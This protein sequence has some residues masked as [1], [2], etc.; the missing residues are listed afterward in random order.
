M[1]EIP[2]KLLL[3]RFGQ[4]EEATVWSRKKPPELRVAPLHGDNR[5]R[6]LGPGGVN[7]YVC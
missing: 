6:G 7:L 3:K 2:L 4:V 5:L 1:S